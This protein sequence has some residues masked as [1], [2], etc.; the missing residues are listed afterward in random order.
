MSSPI[1]LIKNN[2]KELPHNIEAEQSIIGSILVSNEIF[3]EINNI[4][5][6]SNFYDPKHQKIFA[7]MEKLIFGG[8]LANPITLKN[9]FEN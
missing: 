3:D 6:S 7:A 4:I 5:R 1:T 8:M 2:A 9:H